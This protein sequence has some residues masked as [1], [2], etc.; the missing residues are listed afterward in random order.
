LA[1]F[2]LIVGVCGSGKSTLERNLRLRWS[3]TLSSGNYQTI[4]DMDVTVAGRVLFRDESKLLKLSGGDAHQY[5]WSILTDAEYQCT[6][7]VIWERFDSPPNK[8]LVSLVN[9][10]HAITL[11]HLNTDLAV[12]IARRDARSPKGTGNSRTY[13]LADPEWQAKRDII[14]SNLGIEVVY[15]AIDDLRSRCEFV[16]QL[17]SITPVYDKVLIDCYGHTKDV[18][19]RFIGV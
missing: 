19:S 1:H 12:G 11:L 10:G 5:D 4:P 16:E 18:V 8:I 13:Y 7:R 17:L 9:S 6:G 15:V 14:M 3:G 2:Y